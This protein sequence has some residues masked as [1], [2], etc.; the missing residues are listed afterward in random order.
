MC[1]LAVCLLFVPLVLNYFDNNFLIMGGES[2]F[3]LQQSKEIALKNVHYAPLNYLQQNLPLDMLGFIP[4]LIALVSLILFNYIA[5][6]ENLSRKLTFLFQL[7][8]VFSP[9]FI[10]TYS[11]LSYYSFFVFLSLIGFSLLRTRRWKYVATIPF[12]L[13]CFFDVFSTL[14]LFLAITFYLQNKGKNNK[15]LYALMFLVL[16]GSMLWQPL[17]LGPFQEMNILR[18]FVSDLGGFSGI[19][20]FT[21][22]LALIGLGDAWKNKSYLSLYIF[23]PLTVAGFLYNTIAIFPL[24]IILCFFA[25]LGFD[26]LFYKQWEF[27]GLKKF[28]VLIVILGILFS[29]LSYLDRIEQFSV[30]KEEQ[31]ALEWLQGDISLDETF[32]SDFESGFYVEYFTNRKPISYSQKEI[33]K[34]LSATYVDEL[35]PSLEEEMVSAV[36]V[37]SSMRQTLPKKQGLLFLLKNE[38]FKLSLEAEKAEVWDF[39]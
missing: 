32:L 18:D 7:F 30:S 9:T 34:L 14:L 28:A 27:K 8:L 21:L 17:I 31:E 20:F 36:Y 37:T 19:S 24:T 10:F 29:S 11:T 4:P 22:I 3:H 15:Y 6:K 5:K 35:F 2:F 23:V 39:R 26:K 13:A 12:L 33:E 38:R 16:I 25:A 1:L